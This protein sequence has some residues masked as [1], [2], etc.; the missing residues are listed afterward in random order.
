MI[1]LKKNLV[2]M[3]LGITTLLAAY[4]CYSAY[5][6]WSFGKIDQLR[7]ADAV[8]VLGAAAWGDEPSPV[9]RERINHAIRLH[10]QGYADKLIFTGGKGEGDRY[11]ESEVARAYA[12]KRGVGAEHIVIETESKITEQNLQYASRLASQHRLSSFLVVSDPLHM[13][14]AMLMAEHAGLEAYSS[15]TRT[16]AYQSWN[17]RIPFLLRE[18]FFYVGYKC[19]RAFR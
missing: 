16:S 11:A 19:S 18:L 7:K 1:A 15:P 9:L 12:I 13:K 2:R 3:L 5:E 8:I 4:V 6:I 14:R 10:E 17:S